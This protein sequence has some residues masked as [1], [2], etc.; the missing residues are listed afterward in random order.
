MVANFAIPNNTVVMSDMASVCN[1][2]S[3]SVT[4]TIKEL[5]FEAADVTFNFSTNQADE[6][7]TVYWALSGSSISYP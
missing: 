4:F 7:S 3:V 5:D 2:E 1:N 6:N